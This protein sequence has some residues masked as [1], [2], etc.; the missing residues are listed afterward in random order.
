MVP[1]ARRPRESCCLKQSLLTVVL[2]L[3]KWACMSIVAA[4]L[5]NEALMRGA[6]CS[7][8]HRQGMEPLQGHI[9]TGVSGA[10]YL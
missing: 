5:S 2:V 9:V 10:P 6:A 7:W 1:V 3:T 8:V 4:L